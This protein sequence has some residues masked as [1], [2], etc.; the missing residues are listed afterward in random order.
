MDEDIKFFSQPESSQPRGSWLDQMEFDINLIAPDNCRMNNSFGNIFCR[1]DLKL[2]GDTKFPILSGK[3]E[4][5]SGEIYF[6]DRSFNLIKAKVLFNNKFQI[7]PYIDLQSE[8]FIKN[9]RIRFNIRGPASR[10]KP[11]FRSS[12]PLPPQD[13]LA[14]ISLG[15]LFKRP[16][17]TEL[18][19]QMST[20]SM[21]STEL[22]ENLGKR[23]KKIFGIDLLKFDPM[24]NGTSLEGE[25]RLSVGKAIAKNFIIVYSTNISTARQEILYL[26]YQIS[27]SISLIGMRNED[28]RYSI[29]IRFRK[30]R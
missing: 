14:L 20:T 8:A 17:S 10:I 22:T 27:P 26:V 29:D 3:I 28:G 9:Y 15:E 16:T 25:S 7:D 21:I 5:N 2:T 6:S 23:V 19:S 30:R 11:E 4:S 13:V 1:A 12:P 24:I 18:S